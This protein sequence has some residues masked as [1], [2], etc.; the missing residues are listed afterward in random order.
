[1]NHF[2]VLEN[3]NNNKNEFRK[4]NSNENDTHKKSSLCVA[5]NDAVSIET[6]F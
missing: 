5:M 6:I 2:L 1:M 3:N 4:R